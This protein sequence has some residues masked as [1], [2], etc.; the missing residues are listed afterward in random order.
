M[1]RNKKK[2]LANNNYARGLILEGTIITRILMWYVQSLRI[3]FN[4]ISRLVTLWKRFMLPK[5]KQKCNTV[6]FSFKSIKMRLFLEAM[7]TEDGGST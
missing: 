2:Q 7:I 1:N 5:I 3:L 4:F 6:Q